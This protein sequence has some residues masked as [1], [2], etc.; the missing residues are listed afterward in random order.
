MC[1]NML[2]QESFKSNKLGTN[3]FKK[4]DLGLKVTCTM[5]TKMIVF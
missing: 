1:I 3:P 2:I 5:R 4:V